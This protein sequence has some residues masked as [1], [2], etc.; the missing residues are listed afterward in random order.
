VGYRFV[1]RAGGKLAEKQWYQT[2]IIELSP[3]DELPAE[4]RPAP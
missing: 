1:D 3:L 2:D 4:L